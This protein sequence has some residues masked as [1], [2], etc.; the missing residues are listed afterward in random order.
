MNPAIPSSNVADSARS[1]GFVRLLPGIL[2]LAVI[3]YAGKIT[4]Q[5]IAGNI[6][7]LKER[8]LGVEVF[9]RPADYDTSQDPVVR[10]SAAEIKS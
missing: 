9:G 5:S 1:G 4:E 3:G 6:D 8:C 10:A 7:S 2:L